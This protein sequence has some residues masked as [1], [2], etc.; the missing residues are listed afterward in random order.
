MKKLLIIICFSLTFFPI[1]AQGKMVLENKELIKIYTKDEA[2][3]SLCDDIDVVKALLG[4]PN[5]IEVEDRFSGDMDCYNLESVY[6]SGISL[7]HYKGFEKII[8]IKIDNDSFFVTN[9]KLCVG[10]S[11]LTHILDTY[12]ELTI[13]RNKINQ[14]ENGHEYKTI[15]FKATESLYGP[16][17]MIYFDFNIENNECMAIK[18]LCTEE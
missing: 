11:T 8:G 7:Y 14:D 4:S 13:A 3:F 15:A 2:S 9:E 17:L 16:L 12:Q 1:F 18:L 5:K 6:Y 10:K